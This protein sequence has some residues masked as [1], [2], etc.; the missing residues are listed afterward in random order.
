MRITDVPGIE[1]LIVKGLEDS[2]ARYF[3]VEKTYFVS[4]SDSNER[5]RIL[6]QNKDT[7]L[8]FPA[9]FISLTNG[10][11]GDFYN[12]RSMRRN[13]S[14]AGNVDEETI[15][16]SHIVPV[17]M[18]FDV[19]MSTDSFKSILQFFRMWFLAATAGPLN[20]NVDY[21]GLAVLIRAMAAPDLTVP[22]R[23]VSLESPSYF[24]MVGQVAV[25]GYVSPDSLSQVP[26]VTTVTSNIVNS[27]GSTVNISA[28]P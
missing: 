27:K 15:N 20:F 8:M 19:V 28:V 18:S 21:D 14:Y 24:E 12:A 11:V 1:E 6:A 23:D 22:K 4:T 7:S 16:K 17:T 10:T 5:M 9:I 25:Q 26:R 3:G 13:G 2:V